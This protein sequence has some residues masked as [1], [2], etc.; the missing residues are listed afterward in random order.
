MSKKSLAVSIM[1]FTAIVSLMLATTQIVTT[2]V[3]AD[4]HS[5]QKIWVGGGT[6]VTAG[7][8]KDVGC[9]HAQVNKVAREECEGI[10]GEKCK[11]EKLK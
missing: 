6:S 7:C 2:K 9:D 1:I 3:Y 10:S 8:S 4:K 5:K 11:Q